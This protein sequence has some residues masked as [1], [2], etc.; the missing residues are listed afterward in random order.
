[1]KRLNLVLAG[2][3]VGQSALATVA[4][5]PGDDDGATTVPL[6]DLPRESISTIRIW[7]G[8]R[9]EDDPLVLQ[10]EP[11][12]WHIDSAGGYPADE[13]KVARV[14]DAFVDA[15]VSNPL[16]ES[17]TAWA[18]LKVADDDFARR[19]EL[20]GEAGTV[21]LLVGPGTGRAATV[22]RVGDDAVYRL[23][24]VSQWSIG[25]EP[26]SYTDPQLVDVSADDIE[27]LAITGQEGGIR[28]QRV[29]ET[30]VAPALSG[31]RTVDQEAVRDLLGKVVGLRLV[32]L[33]DDPGAAPEAE[34]TVSWTVDGEDGSGGYVLGP[35]EDG[36]RAVRLQ[37]GAHT[38]LVS[39]YSVK[40]IVEASLESLSRPASTD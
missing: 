28:L 31:D 14:L 10:K 11:D 30:W 6:V 17:E 16:A 29:G 22:R 15:R 40:P 36:R 23:R 18:S 38:A 4:W 3:A 26:R 33:P 39:A 7:D 24:G 27:S 25:A 9:D 37:G 32:A 21:E 13:D 35:E 1:M 19:V 5:W 2:L 20:S 12:G 8:S 34:L